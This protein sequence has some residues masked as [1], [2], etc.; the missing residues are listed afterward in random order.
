[1]AESNTAEQIIEEFFSDE[2][3]SIPLHRLDA[4]FRLLSQLGWNI[5]SQDCKDRDAFHLH[6]NAFNA[7]QT[8]S[9]QQLQIQI[10]QATSVNYLYQSDDLIIWKE[11]ARR[12]ENQTDKLFSKREFE[13]YNLLLSGQSLPAMS[14]DLGI[15]QRTIEKHVEN[16]YKKKG[17][18]SYNELLFKSLTNLSS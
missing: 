3:P 7:N 16:I 6:G 14:K 10:E 4:L 17:V 9:L 5:A 15:S 1:M 18:N 13:V 11:Q 8:V 12:T 2:K